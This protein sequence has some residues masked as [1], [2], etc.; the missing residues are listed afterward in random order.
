MNTIEIFD[1]HVE[2]Y[3]EWF[4]RHAHAFRSEVEAVRDMLPAGDHLSGVE[5]G[6]GTG[7][8]AAALGIK[9]GV[10]PAKNMRKLAINRGIEIMDGIAEH[11]PYGDLRFDFVTMVFCVSYLTHVGAAMREVHRVLKKD[12]VFVLGFLDRHSTIGKMYEAR[13]NESTFYR[14]ANF[15]SVD[16]MVNE[17]ANAGFRHFKISQTLFGKLEDITSFQP[18]RPGYGE[19]SFVVIGATKKHA[20][21]K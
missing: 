19:G 7:R 14:H 11:L 21:E 1:S 20:P 2:E 6:L 5:I 17:L 12:G 9:E 10:E 16:R 4:E 15:Y 3:E 8:F 18:A 13:K